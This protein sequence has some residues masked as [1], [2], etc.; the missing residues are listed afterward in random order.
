LPKKTWLLT[1][2]YDVHSYIVLSLIRDLDRL[3]KMTDEYFAL[4]NAAS[5]LHFRIKKQCKMIDEYFALFNAASTLHFR[6]KKQCKMIDEYFALFNAVSSTRM[7][8]ARFDARLGPSIGCIG[9]HL[10]CSVDVLRLNVFFESPVAG[11]MAFQS[12][13]VI[14]SDFPTQQFR[15]MVCVAAAAV[16]TPRRLAGE[17][18]GVASLLLGDSTRPFVA[19][20]QHSELGTSFLVLAATRR[21]QLVLHAGS[22]VFRSASEHRAETP[23]ACDKPPARGD[24]LQNVSAGGSNGAG[25]RGSVGGSGGDD[26]S[27]SSLS[28]TL[29]SPPWSTIGMPNDEDESHKVRPR[30]ALLLISDTGG[31]HRASAYAIRDAM[32]ELYP[33]SF[34][35]FIVDMWV[36]WTLWPFSSMPQSYQFLAKNPPLWRAAY[37]YGSFPI[38]R[39]LT[40]EVTNAIVHDRVRAAIA[41]IRPDLIISL[42]PLTQMLP[43]RVLRRMGLREYIPFVTV[44]TD[45]GG[46]H[47][48]W[49]DPEADLIFVASDAVRNLAIKCG[50]QA[51]RI[52]QH[53]LPV[54]P[55][56]WADAERNYETELASVNR[57]QRITESRRAWRRRLGFLEE[58]RRT[59]LIVGGGDGV[60]GIVRIARAVVER[61]DALA[62][63]LHEAK[64]HTAAP[65]QVIVVCGRNERARRDL[66]HWEQ[67]RLKQH[68]RPDDDRRT[69]MAVFGFASN[70]G[71]LMAASDAIVTKAGPGT[72]AE[73]LI[74]GL[75]IMLSGFLPGQ[76]EGNVPFVV[77][78]GVGE[79]EQGPNAIANRLAEWLADDTL[80]LQMAIRAR[81]LGKPLATYEICQDIA[82][83]AQK[84]PGYPESLPGV[85]ASDL[86]SK[87]K[88]GANQDTSNSAAGAA[89]RQHAPSNLHSGRDFASSTLQFRSA[90]LIGIDAAI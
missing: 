78:H 42:H 85:E 36:E 16:A 23:P 81:D 71:E 51:E 62:M 31:G 7:T 54:R 11:K 83:L 52:R 10:V 59:V 29:P 8:N 25:Q 87:S 17:P 26:A 79:Y 67:S 84:F 9:K 20:A 77:S 32:N 90:W 46:A 6:I 21:N 2:G 76:E 69:R 22:D 27:A 68:H 24:W 48:T 30:R 57:V 1:D 4:F 39:R 18:S 63:E 74:R 80:L 44:V 12:A 61:L 37:C 89:M 60:G 88:S 58:H 35:W 43:L 14:P 66:V 50:V 72:I 82:E 5:T 75:P 65:F 38:T 15:R 33:G 13:F 64:E 41:Y 45:L 55:E 19:S 86:H 34:E 49:F 40:E 28:D 47:A 3:P 56:F 73:A 53:G 70:M